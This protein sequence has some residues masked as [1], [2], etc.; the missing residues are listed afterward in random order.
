MP[1]TPCG[2]MRS[3]S[4][5]IST[6]R[7]EWLRAASAGVGTKVLAAI[8]AERAVSDKGVK[9]L[10][11]LNVFEIEQ[12]RRL[13]HREAEPGH[14]AILATDTIPKVVGHGGAISNR[15]AESLFK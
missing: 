2:S 3:D 9:Q 15:R 6:R 1:M 7:G 11:A 13:C 5:G 4:R 10:S 14:L 12:A 8:G